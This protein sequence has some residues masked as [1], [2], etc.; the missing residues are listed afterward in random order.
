VEPDVE[1][2]DVADG[3]EK[4]GA[5]LPGEEPVERWMISAKR[6]AVTDQ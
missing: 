5:A 1:A 6:P 4:V 3:M 2:P